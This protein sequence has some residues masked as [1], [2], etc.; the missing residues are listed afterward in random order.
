MLAA[1]ILFILYWLWR[2]PRYQ[3][4]FSLV[5][6]L[7]GYS[8]IQRTVTYHKATA[9]TANATH[10]KVLSYNVRMFNIYGDNETAS[11]HLVDWVRDFDA[12]IK[13][14]QELYNSDK[15]TVY[16]TMKRVAKGVSSGFAKG[17]SQE[18]Y[19]TIPPKLFEHK[20]GYV[21]LVIF[22]KYPIIYS[23][24]IITNKHSNPDRIIE[25]YKVNKGVLADIVIH[26]DTIR[27]IN[28]H[29]QSMSIRVENL[30]EKRE[31]DGAKRS[32]LDIFRRLREGFVSRAEEIALLEQEIAKSPYPVLVCGDFNDMPYSYTYS[33][34][35][36]HLRNAFEKAGRGFGFTYNERLF[37]LRID[38]QFFGEQL[39]VHNFTTHRNVSFS[40]HFPISATYSIK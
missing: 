40:D 28:V 10:F 20:Q 2:A 9:P 19:A 26:K 13:C 30:L 24:N 35:R 21:G 3:A 16:N 33:R 5:T 25:K 31:Y 23:K 27:V 36:K 22:S 29:L 39:D 6:V 7:I 15:S 1:H 4:L 12:D 14:I 11:V 37:F 18:Y 32:F 38:N 34:I 8:F 17:G